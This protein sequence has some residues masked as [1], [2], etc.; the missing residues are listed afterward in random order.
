MSQSISR[1]GFINTLCLM[2]VASPAL[3]KKP[4]YATNSKNPARLAQGKLKPIDDQFVSV[5]GWILPAEI[6]TQGT[7]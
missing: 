4:F 5:D 3:A 7:V 2:I 6:L 1:R